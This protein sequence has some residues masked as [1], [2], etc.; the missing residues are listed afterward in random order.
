MLAGFGEDPP[1][2]A[3]GPNRFRVDDPP[4][5]VR[6]SVIED[7]ELVMEELLASER[8]TV[9]VKVEPVAPTAEELAAYVGTYY[10]PELGTWHRVYLRDGKLFVKQRKNPEQ[11]LTPA[12]RDTFVLPAASLVFRRDAH[13][14]VAGCE[15][16]ND[17]IRYL[18]FD[19]M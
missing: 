8:D 15:L 18:R 4:H 12:T 5:E 7:D 14:A 11:E 6:F 9:Y 16:F 13:G 3:I 2:T 10:A 1:L 19:R 17:R